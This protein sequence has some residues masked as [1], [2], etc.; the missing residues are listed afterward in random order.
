MKKLNKTILAASVL[1]LIGAT[2]CAN[3]NQADT[4]S[5][6]NVA[7]EINS[8]FYSFDTGYTITRV[9]TA[10]GNNGDYI[11]A[12]SYEG[13]ILGFDFSGKKLWENKLSGFMNHEVWAADI[14]GDGQDEILAANADGNLYALSS[15]GK[16][17]WQF[18]QNEAPMYAVGVIH[19]QGKP[20]VVCGGLDKNVYYL[21]GNGKLIKTLESKTYSHESPFGLGKLPDKN[22]HTAN[23]IRAAKQ[24]DGSELLVILGTANHMQSTGSF[25]V[26][27]PFADKPI[28][29]Q[30]PKAKKGIGDLTL[31]DIDADGNDELLFG[32]SASGPTCTSYVFDIE[33]KKTYPYNFMNS[34]AGKKNIDRFG[35]RVSQTVTI[36]NGNSFKYFTLVG[37]SILLADPQEKTKL[38]NTNSIKVL[39]S[40][41]SY[42]DMWQHP[43]RNRIILASSQSGGSAIH[44]I[45]VNKPDWQDKYRN[46]VPIG[47]ISEILKNTAEAQ[48]QVIKFKRPSHE[49]QPLP[50]HFISENQK[51]KFTKNK[52]EQLRQNYPQSPKFLNYG[53][54]TKPEN[55]DRSVLTN[56]Y[57]QKTRDSRM[58]YDL[59]TEKARK[60]LRSA[61]DT[62]EIGA[63]FWGGHGNDPFFFSFETHKDY[64]SYA[65][66]K[67]KMSVSIW[68]ELKG[69]DENFNFV[70][71]EL[72][73][74]IAEYSQGK[75]SFINIR[76][77]HVFWHGDV[78]LPAWKRLISGEF[79]DVFIPSME[80]TSDKSMELTVASR[81]GVWLAGSTNQWGARSARD[82]PSFDRQRMHNHQMLPNH[83]LRQMVFNIANGATFLNNFPVDQKYTSILW[84]MIAT[85]ALYVPKR[86]ELLSINPVHLSIVNP[87]PDYLENSN[88]VKWTTF[89]DEHKENSNKMV[90]SRMN[91]TWP[92]APN[93]AWDFSN[94]A[95]GEKERRLNFVPDYPYGTVLI[96][97]PQ[98]GAEKEPRG[99]LKDKLHPIYKNTLVEYITDGRN[100]YSAD[101]KQKYAADEYYKVIEKDIQQKTTLMP[102]TVAGETAWVVAQS[103]PTHLRLTLVDSGYLN[104]AERQAVIN[105]NT[106]KPKAIT[107][108]LTGEKYQLSSQNQAK[109]TVPTGLFSF[110]DIELEQP[111]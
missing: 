12:N 87:D 93:T 89:F 81:M 46:N 61:F 56:T 40:K 27:E 21:D 37:S 80:E 54:G 95:L 111:L 74:P 88:N 90:I 30:K 109:I 63:A 14:N 39:T 83:F 91:G 8:G 52:I 49:R 25:Y 19:H 34:K 17:L 11:V 33:S 60:T 55:W 97:P 73:Y 1:A 22:R 105:F 76:T 15:S 24:K 18:K 64:I 66:S 103:S 38:P 28:V 35:Y 99:L 75:N 85:G 102:L 16:L 44:V 72:T 70:M 26:F 41:F 104:P 96:T 92:G 42:N 53:I 100:Y 9:R 107:N 84:D 50:V 78:Y 43:D 3:A 48:A 6:N 101:L 62:K 79:K 106:I 108:I 65:N 31:F 98:A 82:N 94:Y 5:A 7:G 69:H 23:F 58:K 110:I 57:Y 13:T 45:N 67:G 71:N 10:S 47:K 36:P 20:Y 77:K 68:P 4:A 59:P 2:G 32:N 86:E 29:A 51:D